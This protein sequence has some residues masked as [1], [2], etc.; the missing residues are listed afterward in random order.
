MLFHLSSN[1]GEKIMK[2]LKASASKFMRSQHLKEGAFL[3][4]V[5]S[6]TFRPRSLKQRRTPLD[7]CSLKLSINFVPF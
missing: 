7:F 4:D 6:F 2:P 5:F 1:F 3:G